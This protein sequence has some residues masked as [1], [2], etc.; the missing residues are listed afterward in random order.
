MRNIILLGASSL[1]LSSCATTNAP[2][3]AAAP[4]WV[5]PQATYDEKADSRPVEQVKASCPVDSQWQSLEWKKV[6]PLANACIRAKDWQRVEK[7]GDWLAKQAPLTPWGPFYLGIAAESRKDYPRAIWMLELALKKAPKEGIFQYELGR[8][9]WD[10][11]NDRAAVAAMKAASDLSPGLVDAHA[12]VGQLALQRQDYA[13]GE[14]YFQK[15]LAANA[16]HL[17]SLLGMASV[18]IGKKDFARAEEYLARAVELSPNSSKARLALAQLQEENLK[19]YDEA[20]NSYKRIK[21]LSGDKKLDE[22]IPLNLDEKIHNLEKSVS[23]VIKSSQ[24]SERK[25]SAERQ[26]A[27]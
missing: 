13:E 2:V 16:K 21:Q 27:K 1:L 17:V 9:H 3:K 7:M 18:T 20:L 15:A 5:G 24:L 22:A 11:K 6:M 8:I 10:L 4:T 25:P 19:K 23:Q 14:R 12:V 26:V